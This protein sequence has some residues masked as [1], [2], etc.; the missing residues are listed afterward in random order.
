M[1]A[2]CTPPGPGGVDTPPR[3][4]PIAAEAV[5]ETIEWALRPG[6]LPPYD[7]LV[8]LEQALLVIVADLWAVVD[9]ADRRT[10]AASGNGWLRA[11]LTAIR[12]QT[13]VG[14]GSGLVSA[15]TQ[16]RALARSCQWLQD[17]HGDQEATG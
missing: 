9:E 15:H 10:P 4:A 7:E 12:Y 13:A 14:L 16:V 11:G 2:E 6:P 5:T 3:L 8:A 17:R 1:R